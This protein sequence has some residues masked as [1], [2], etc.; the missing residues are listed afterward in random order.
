MWT[1]IGTSPDAG[2]P[3]LA[4]TARAR[5][6]PKGATAACWLARDADMRQGMLYRRR[7]ANLR[8][9]KRRNIHERAR[10]WRA[11]FCMAFKQDTNNLDAAAQ[12]RAHQGRVAKT[13]RPHGVKM[14]P[15][16]H[17]HPCN[18]RTRV[19]NCRHW[20]LSSNW[21][22]CKS[23]VNASTSTHS[24]QSARAPTQ[25]RTGTGWHC[26]D[27]RRRTVEFFAHPVSSIHG[28]V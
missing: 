25:L 28:G 17:Q 1:P 26:H 11:D 23:P 18:S 2:G 20:R 5:P 27:T 19:P 8:I 7:A 6:G 4:P 12:C 16:T 24:R 9:D 22:I 10:G 15:M 14:D 13:A 3:R 21:T